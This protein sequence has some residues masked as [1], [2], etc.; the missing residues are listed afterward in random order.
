MVPKSKPTLAE[1]RK[2]AEHYCAYQ[3]RSHLEVE[4]KLHSLGLNADEI[5]DVML[6][7]VNHKFLNEERF[8]LAYAGGKYRLKGWGKKKIIY[9]LKAKGINEKLIEKA[10]SQIP[11]HDYSHT[12]QELIKK[13]DAG[14]KQPDKMKRMAAINRYLAQKGFET[15]LII[16]EVKKYYGL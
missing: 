3:E 15:D 6:H 12:I 13:K 2:K 8:A 1:A 7:L 14:L 10:V 11:D 4:R 5:S 9:Q 16:S